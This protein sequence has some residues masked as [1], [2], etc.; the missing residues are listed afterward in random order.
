M[1]WQSDIVHLTTFAERAWERGDRPEI[2]V[3]HTGVVGYFV[4]KDEPNHLSLLD[5]SG[6]TLDL[7]KRYVVE[8]EIE[9]NDRK[10][11]YY[12]IEQPNRLLPTMNSN[13]KNNKSG[14]LLNNQLA[15]YKG[16]KMKGNTALSYINKFAE[17][18][19]YF[20]L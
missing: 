3:A 13:N 4:F 17:P 15:E 7:L 16:G 14:R 19:S 2:I 12:F 9:A 8:R 20:R 18:A 11:S 5:L 10:Y 1:A 6:T